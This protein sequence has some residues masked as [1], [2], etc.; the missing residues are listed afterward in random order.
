MARPVKYADELTEEE[1]AIFRAY[2]EV[3]EV[4]EHYAR[5]LGVVKEK[6]HYRN[7]STGST[8]LIALSLGVSHQW[9]T[10]I[11]QSALRKLRIALNKQQSGLK[12]NVS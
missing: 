1:R 2:L 9:V 3:P 5:E 8:R 7:G 10:K 6:R 12:N 4:R 11:E